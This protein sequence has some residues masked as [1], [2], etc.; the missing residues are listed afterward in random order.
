VVCEAGIYL[1]ILLILC[2]A[3]FVSNFSFLMKMCM[4]S[5]GTGK[6]CNLCSMFK[7]IV[8]FQKEMLR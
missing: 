5:S 1:F 6:I 8:G 7:K 3:E 4:Y 2:T